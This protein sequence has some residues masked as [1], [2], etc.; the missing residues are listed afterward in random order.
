M[1]SEIIEEIDLKNKEVLNA[2][3]QFWYFFNVVNLLC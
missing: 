3:K 1:T 2:K